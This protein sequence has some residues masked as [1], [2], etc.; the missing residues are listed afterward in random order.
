ME[1]IPSLACVPIHCASKFVWERYPV[2]AVTIDARKV[3]TPR[4]QVIARRPRHAAMKNLP[5]RCTTIAKKNS[6]TDQRWH[7]LTKR[8]TVETC[9]HW[10]PLIARMQPVAITT[11]N[12]AVVAT[13]NT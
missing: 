12:A 3:T 5:H 10:G 7:E 9:H 13:P 8:P 2:N 4:I 6:S 11:I 1:L